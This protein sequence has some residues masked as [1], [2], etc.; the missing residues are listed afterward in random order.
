MAYVNKILENMLNINE[1]FG[2]GG[3]WARDWMNIRKY[4][5]YKWDLK[6]TI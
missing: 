1:H 2:W 3:V 5:K 6:L 4:V